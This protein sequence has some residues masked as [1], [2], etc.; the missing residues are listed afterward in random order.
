MRIRKAAVEDARGIA[1]VHVECWKTTYKGFFSDLYLSSL[2]TGQR[3]RQWIWNFNN[4]NPNEAVFVAENDAGEIIGFCSG[5]QARTQ[6]FTYEAELYAIYI[7]KPYQQQGVGGQLVSALVS[8]LKAN[9][10]NSFM[11]WVLAGNPSVEFYNRMG[12]IAFSEKETKRGE[13]I[14]T[15]IAYGWRSLQDL[16][17]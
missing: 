13:D 10:Y 12:G 11:L 8:H 3:E 4:P 5:G 16:D 15:E 14:M 17:I 7:L 1:H 6:E 2:D 9:Q